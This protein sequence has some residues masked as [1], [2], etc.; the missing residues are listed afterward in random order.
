M[1]SKSLSANNGA[2]GVEGRAVTPSDTVALVGGVCRAFYIGGAG[3]LSVIDHA[4][5]TVLFI[6][7]LAGTILPFG[8][9]HVR[10]TGTTATNIVALW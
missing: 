1:G 5:N 8:G 4:G 9:T 10:A 2:P 6:G 3:D 7:L